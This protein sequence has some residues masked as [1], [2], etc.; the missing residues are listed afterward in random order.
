MIGGLTEGVQALQFAFGS[1]S[2]S[3][4]HVTQDEED[5]LDIL[6]AVATAIESYIR[7]GTLL[8]A[9]LDEQ[10]AK[11]LAAAE[12]QD[13]LRESLEGSARAN[14]NARDAAFDY[15][16]VQDILEQ[17]VIDSTEAAYDYSNATAAVIGGLDLIT[18]Q[19]GLAIAA[20]TGVSTMVPTPAVDGW[21]RVANELGL[22]SDSALRL[23]VQ[24]I[25]AAATLDAVAAV[26]GGRSFE[27]IEV[28]ASARNQISG[29]D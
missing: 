1:L 8:A 23:Q 4:F 27:D 13:I 10:G 15:E 11:A 21:T 16:D 26:A 17:Q 7:R 24:S 9:V 25:A 19:A 6:G 3:Q 12:A 20:M 18:G 5:H 22:A 14:R 29:I 28:F 2:D